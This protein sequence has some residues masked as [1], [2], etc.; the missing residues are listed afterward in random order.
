MTRQEFLRALEQDL[1]DVSAEERAE[2]VRFYGEYFDEA[3]PER[4]QALLEELGDALPSKKG[5]K[6]GKWV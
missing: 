6:G 1:A 5:T 3:G 2:A 4:E